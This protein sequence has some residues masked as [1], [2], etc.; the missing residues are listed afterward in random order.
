[1]T[2]LNID[3]TVAHM[4]RCGM[5]SSDEAGGG[6]V[7]NPTGFMTNSH[8]LKDQLSKKCMGG[9]KHIQL[10]GGRAQ[11]CQLDPDKLCRSIL[12][13]F[14]NEFENSGKIKANSRDMLNVSQENFDP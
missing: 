6:H 5:K 3:K 10:L 1:M 4:C 7:K 13:G 12:T 11:A 8:F 2:D 14:R 9:H